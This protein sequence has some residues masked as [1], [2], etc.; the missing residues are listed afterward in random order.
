MPNA[1]H[2]VENLRLAS[3]RSALRKSDHRNV[4]VGPR[5]GQR[6]PYGRVMKTW[7]SRRIGELRNPA[8]HPDSNPLLIARVHCVADL[9]CRSRAHR[10]CDCPRVPRGPVDDWGIR[11]SA[12]DNGS[13]GRDVVPTLAARSSACRLAAYRANKLPELGVA[14]PSAGRLREH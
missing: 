9:R 11:Q 10:R 5:S 14:G 3:L 12:S 6:N 1:S 4:N 2:R 8:P 7:A 13:S